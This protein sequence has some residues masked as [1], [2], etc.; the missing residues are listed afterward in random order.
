[1]GNSKLFF[2]L[3]NSKCIPISVVM[4]FKYSMYVAVFNEYQIYIHSV[5]ILWKG[6]FT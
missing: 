3:V 5:W 4:I 6:L 2:Y 1:M